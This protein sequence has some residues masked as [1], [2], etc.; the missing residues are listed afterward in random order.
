MWD[1]ELAG[2]K[3]TAAWVLESQ[4]EGELARERGVTIQDTIL[5]DAQSAP[6]GQ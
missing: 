4:F 1:I 3:R 5:G 2:R 6:V